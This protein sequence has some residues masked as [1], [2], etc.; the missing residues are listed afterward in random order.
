[1]VNWRHYLQPLTAIGLRD[2][3]LVVDLVRQSGRLSQS[4][5][6]LD[7]V[8]QQTD[9]VSQSD[10]VIQSRDVLGTMLR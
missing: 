8:S 9:F 2:D 6:Q 4:V 1:M 10:L 3:Y 5:S 7:L